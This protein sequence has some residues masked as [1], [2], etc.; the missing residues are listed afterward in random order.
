MLMIMVM[1]IFVF[2]LMFIYIVMFHEQEHR[3]RLG[4]VR[5][6]K[7]SQAGG[8]ETWTWTWTRTW[9]RTRKQPR[10]RTQKWPW[11][12]KDSYVR[13][14]AHLPPASS[15]PRH[16]LRSW[17]SGDAPPKDIGES[18]TPPSSVRC[19]TFLYLAQPGIFHK[20]IGPNARY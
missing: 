20:K 7:H 13:C 10:T 3:H 4:H 15:R 2:V 11:T 12:L 1:L 17:R 5:V 18:Q 9:T 16:P 14:V 19:W 6:H 8:Q